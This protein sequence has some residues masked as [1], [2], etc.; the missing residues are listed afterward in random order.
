MNQKYIIFR[1]FYRLDLG[2]E[3]MSINDGDK[4]LEVNGSPV[5]DHNPENLENMLNNPESVLQVSSQ[6]C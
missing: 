4:I 2:G 3:L 6:N 1:T 5:K